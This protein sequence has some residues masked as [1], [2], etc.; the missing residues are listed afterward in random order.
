MPAFTPPGRCQL[1]L[2][3]QGEPLP[4]SCSRSW[5]LA[6]KGRLYPLVSQRIQQSRQRQWGGTPAGA[7]DAS[8]VGGCLPGDRARPGADVSCVPRRWQLLHKEAFD[9]PG[10]QPAAHVW[11]LGQQLHLSPAECS[12]GEAEGQWPWCQSHAGQ[13]GHEA[14]RPAAPQLPVP[15]LVS[16][17]KAMFSEMRQACRQQ[18]PA[19]WHWPQPGFSLQL[20][21]SC[22]QSP[23][24]P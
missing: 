1:T 2:S 23:T 18:E 11:Q 5:G 24:R 15:T 12:P 3:G 17:T 14:T 21:S 8:P 13:G 10:S 7:R 19:W 6:G 20:L 9:E 22:L 4:G 16:K